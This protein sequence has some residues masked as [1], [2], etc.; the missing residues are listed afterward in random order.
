MR[1]KYIAFTVGAPDDVADLKSV[2]RLQ[3]RKAVSRLHG[4]VLE[5]EPD[6]LD[7]AE[8]TLDDDMLRPVTLASDGQT[9]TT[10]AGLRWR[11]IQN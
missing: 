3:P 1:H 10:A 8:R 11:R 4:W 9:M 2:H 5:F 7:E 6:D